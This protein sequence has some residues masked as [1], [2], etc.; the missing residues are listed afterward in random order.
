MYSPGL[1]AIGP[2]G[3]KCIYGAVD[4]RGRIGAEDKVVDL[5]ILRR[6]TL[7]GGPKPR[8][9]D[10]QTFGL[11]GHTQL[12]H[13]DVA[14]KRKQKPVRPGGEITDHQATRSGCKDEIIPPLPPVI[15]SGPA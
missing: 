14:A 2:I 11:I 4:L 3:Q 13:V 12:G 1:S 5:K 15:V 10:T 6:D 7:E 9:T 8:Q